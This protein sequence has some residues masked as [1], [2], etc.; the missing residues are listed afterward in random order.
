[1]T[2]GLDASTEA[3]SQ[4][5][6]IAPIALVELDF[7]SSPV[8]FWSGIGDFVYDG[9]TYTGAG[10]LGFIGPMDEDTDLTRSTMD[11]GLR[12]LPNDIISKVLGQQY[13]GR[14]ATVYLGYLEPETMQ[15]AGDPYPFAAMMDQPNIS[16]GE[17]CQVVLRIEDE[18]AVLDL[19]KVRRYNDADH[20]A[21]YPGDLFLQF[22][23]QTTEKQINWGQK[24]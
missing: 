12:G 18:F 23:E 19:P 20:Q 1:M 7:P 4:A 15:L 2:R 6:V 21:R 5:A 8:R 13:R 16:L 3:A 22:V 14:T 17:A 10:D 9:D 24:L 11:I